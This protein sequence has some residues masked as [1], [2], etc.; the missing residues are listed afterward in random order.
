MTRFAKW[1]WKV[2]KIVFPLCTKSAKKSARGG[3]RTLGL[4]I[5]PDYETDALTNCATQAP[6]I[7]LT[8][9]KDCPIFDEYYNYWAKIYSK[10]W[11]R[12]GRNLLFSNLEITQNRNYIKSTSLFRFWALRPFYV[13]L[14]SHMRWS[15]G[16]V[17]RKSSFNVASEYGS[18]SRVLKNTNNWAGLER[19]D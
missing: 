10:L 5:P 15:R 18:D 9:T 11:A 12:R 19:C 14:S 1:R 13:S 3:V 16:R 17:E 6:G 7:G 8:R 4:Q 2:S